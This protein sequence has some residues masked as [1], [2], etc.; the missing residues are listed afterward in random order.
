MSAHPCRSFLRISGPKTE[1]GALLAN[2]TLNGRISTTTLLLPSTPLA[3][4]P[5]LDPQN[6]ISDQLT[7]GARTVE[8][9]FRHRCP[10]A[11]R[12][13]SHLARRYENVVVQY[14]WYEET[15]GWYGHGEWRGARECAFSD[16]ENYPFWFECNTPYCTAKTVWDPTLDDLIRGAN[17]KD[18]W[19][20]QHQQ[21][22]IIAR[23]AAAAVQ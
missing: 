6:P 4:A 21:D 16:N 2:Y 13:P 9:E 12:W 23:H 7:D 22:A 3:P 19:C 11:T 15:S 18:C 17:P 10:Q 5:I 1:V 14:G 20:A 8:W